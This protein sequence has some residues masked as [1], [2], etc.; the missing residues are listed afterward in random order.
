MDGPDDLA[1]S[2]PLPLDLAL[3]AAQLFVGVSFAVIAWIKLTTPISALAA[4]WAWTG[5]YPEAMVRGIGLIDLAG[6]LGIVLPRLTRIRPGLTVAAAAGCALLQVCAMAFHL[7]R[8]EGEATPINVVYLAL[9]LFVFWGRRAYPAR[10]R[11]RA[12]V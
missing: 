7:S 12:A 2:T 1:R 4:M 9:A 11:G 10:P 3:W 8:G 6:G 5:E